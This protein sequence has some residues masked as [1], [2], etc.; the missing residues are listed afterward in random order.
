MS[1]STLEYLA[2]SLWNQNRLFDVRLE[3]A[4]KTFFLHKLL[5]HQSPY[6][7]RLFADSNTLHLPQPG[8][9]SNATVDGLE[10]CLASLYGI[11]PNITTANV[12][13]VLTAAHLLELETLCDTCIKFIQEGVCLEVFETWHCINLSWNGG[14][15]CERIKEILDVFLCRTAFI[16]TRQ[17]LPALSNE[18]LSHLLSCDS[19]WVPAEFNRFELIVEVL[20][21][22]LR[23]PETEGDESSMES[24]VNETGPILDETTES[25]VL[26]FNNG[27]SS[28]LSCFSTL[29]K[30]SCIYYHNFTFPQL[31]QA[32]EKLTKFS[33]YEAI[34]GVDKALWNRRALELLIV[35]SAWK[36]KELSPVPSLDEASLLESVSLLHGC[37]ELQESFST[38]RFSTEIRDIDSFSHSGN[39]CSEPVYFAGSLF[40][41]LLRVILDEWEYNSTIGIYLQR[42]MM[43]SLKTCDFADSRSR[44][45]AELVFLAG[46]NIIEAIE[47][48]GPIESPC[49]NRGYSKFLPF[50]QLNKY[51]SPNGSLRVTVIFKM[52]FP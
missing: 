46:T 5:I 12:F 30:P 6:L 21:A 42:S 50:T 7:R 36:E 43:S 1:S 23:T 9:E 34:E 45:D 11:N 4:G 14:E 26:D 20:E 3:F 19:L 39:Y 38:L 13:E 51:L 37:P 32:R 27:R 29:L 31:I 10:L 47:L 49:C 48:D 41:V 8:L 28:T 18:Q 52:T 15:Y 16:E 35:H 44:V 24:A 40:H 22:K 17:M 33:F 25:D 2:S